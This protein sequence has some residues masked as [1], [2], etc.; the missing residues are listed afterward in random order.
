MSFIGGKKK[1]QRFDF[2]KVKPP[3]G[4]GREDGRCSV[5]EICCIRCK[6]VLECAPAWPKGNYA[7][8]EVDTPCRM[9]GKQR[10]CG[11]VRDFIVQERII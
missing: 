11:A 7:T 4:M 3:C 10:W 8:D 2:S 5:D 6:Y 1:E 9:Y